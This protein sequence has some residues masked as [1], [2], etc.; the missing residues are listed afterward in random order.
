[1]V[2]KE[3][4]N[5]ILTAQGVRSRTILFT[6][7]FHDRPRIL[8]AFGITFGIKLTLAVREKLPFP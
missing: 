8:I 2:E 1:M 7:S 4:E 6:I 5:S 3:I